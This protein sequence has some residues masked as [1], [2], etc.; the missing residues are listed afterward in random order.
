MLRQLLSNMDAYLG[1]SDEAIQEAKMAVDLT[2]KDLFQG[3][4]QLENL[5]LIY[6]RTGRSD[7]ALDLVDRLLDK[8]YSRPLTVHELRL[9]PRWDP[10]RASPRFKELLER[11]GR[12]SL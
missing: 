1:R 4:E 3:P 5:A 6:A 10:L 11:R 12:G 9:D 8:A 2:A 7:E